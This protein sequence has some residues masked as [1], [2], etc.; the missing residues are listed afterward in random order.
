MS[1]GVK[2][3]Y[4]IM[5]EKEFFRKK[6]RILFCKKIKK[7]VSEWRY[8]VLSSQK[9]KKLRLKVW[10]GEGYKYQLSFSERCNSEHDKEYHWDKDTVE[11]IWIFRAKYPVYLKICCW[12]MVCRKGYDWGKA[13]CEIQ[14][15]MLCFIFSVA[16]GNPSFRVLNKEDYRKYHGNNIQ[17]SSWCIYM[18]GCGHKIEYKS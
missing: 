12:K 17:L 7:F 8:C 4:C 14:F 16:V 3:F 11:K 1:I 10:D 13:W 15:W 2:Y 6:C 9:I 5:S 18:G